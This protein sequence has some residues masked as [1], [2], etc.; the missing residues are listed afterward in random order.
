MA[1]QMN[2]RNQQI[3]QG[4]CQG[5]CHCFS[6]FF[7]FFLFGVGGWGGDK[8]AACQSVDNTVEI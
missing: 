1:Q 4:G 7:S 8:L 5:G 2:I 6:F 3:G